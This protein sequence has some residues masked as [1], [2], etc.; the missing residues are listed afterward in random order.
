MDNVLI[1][2]RKGIVFQLLLT[3]AFSLWL[4]SPNLSAQ[5]GLIDDHEIIR[6]LG[7]KSTLSFSEVIANL[8]QTEVWIPNVTTR[9]RPSY[10]CLRLIETAL[11]GKSAF[12]W[13]LA[14]LGMFWI[15]VFL[16]LRLCLRYWGGALGGITAVVIF[17]H[18]YWSGIFGRLGPAEIY[19]AVGLAIYCF[20][21]DKLQESEPEH[22]TLWW[23]LLS[24]SGIVCVGSKENFLLLV[25]VTCIACYRA[26]KRRT[27]SASAVSLTALFFL[28]SAFVT[29]VILFALK[30]TGVDVYANPVSPAARVAVLCH[31]ALTLKSFVVFFPF[32]A[33]S[34]FLLL[35]L[36]CNHEPSELH[37]AVRNHFCV[38]SWL[39]VL[40]VSQ[41]VF[42][43]GN[44]PTGIRYDLPGM[45]ALD[46]AYILLSLCFFTLVGIMYPNSLP[47]RRLAPS[48]ITCWLL[49]AFFFV[50]GTGQLGKIRTTAQRNSETSIAFQSTLSGILSAAGRDP[51]TPIVLE[52]H[53]PWDIEPLSSLRTYLKASGVSNPTVLVTHFSGL[54]SHKNVEPILA[55]RLTELSLKGG[56]L[57]ASRN[58][59]FPASIIAGS[60]R[61]YVVSFSGPPRLSG[62]FL[63]RL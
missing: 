30:K 23:V 45:I 13:Y 11:W 28:F 53:S 52:S 7:S 4:W 25:P 21:L 57:S 27:L 26:W 20:S 62:I 9:Y 8:K 12:C 22:H 15:T 48:T 2:A 18:N 35:P 31:A 60:P 14:R 58:Q 63:G 19:C 44:W 3:L 55:K 40:L 38:Q 10:Y 42:Y 32:L 24:L 41:M 39:A 6:Y 47:T 33:S 34:I 16:T 36:A 29:A 5:F 46:L 54:T 49:V 1:D 17:A 59:L 50:F 56:D 37:R 61:Y 51:G 43:N